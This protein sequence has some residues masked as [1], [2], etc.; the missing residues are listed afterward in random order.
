MYNTNSTVQIHWIPGHSG[1]PLN[2]IAD[3]LAKAG[4]KVSK[5]YDTDFDPVDTIIN[6]GY[7][8]LT[9]LTSL[10]APWAKSINFITS[11]APAPH[12]TLQASGLAADLRS[13]FF[14]YCTLTN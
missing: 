13:A 3:K 14:R 11:C 10:A 4:A 9:N 8:H 6:H 5:S 2:D 1:I 12:I 7:N